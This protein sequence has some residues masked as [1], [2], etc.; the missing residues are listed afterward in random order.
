[1]ALTLQTAISG[2]PSSTAVIIPSKPTPLS[3]SYGS[4]AAQVSSFQAK[5]ADLGIT[6][7]SP[8]SIAL[9]N[10]WEFVVAFLAA[11]WQRGIAAP[12]NPAYK[13]DEFEFYIEDVK[14]ALVLVPRGA[15]G[16][17]APSVRAAKKFNS[18]VAECYWD[19]A[20]SEI[21]LDV[22]HLGELRGKKEKVLKAEADDVALILH[23][24]YVSQ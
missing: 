16:A 11:S 2:T 4:L 10:S 6:H 23:T 9:I 21:V 24:R 18:A 15:W 1:M 20:K 19:A 12:L 7:A 22:K 17:D 3:V 13:Q 14:S 5:L 8:V